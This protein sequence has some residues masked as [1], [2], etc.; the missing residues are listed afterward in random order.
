MADNT[1]PGS[2]NSNSV[3]NVVVKKIG[4]DLRLKIYF[5]T[6]FHLKVFFKRLKNLTTPPNNLQKPP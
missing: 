6:H 4:G 2:K 3:I 1:Y 5:S